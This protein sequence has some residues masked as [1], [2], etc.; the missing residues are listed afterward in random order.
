MRPAQEP[1]P[2]GLYGDLDL[3]EYT[4]AECPNR[5]L[6]GSYVNIFCMYFN[7]RDLIA[8][9]PC[10][11]RHVRSTFRVCM[12]LREESSPRYGP[13]RLCLFVPCTCKSAEIINAKLGSAGN[14]YSFYHVRMYFLR[15]LNVKMAD[16]F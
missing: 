9:E 8:A 2:S 3:L 7:Q 6:I 13:S 12:P 11:V 10:C 15:F 14:L 5:L 16:L 1:A 4:L